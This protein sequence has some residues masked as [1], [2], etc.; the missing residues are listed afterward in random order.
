MT[1]ITPPKARTIETALGG[2]TMERAGEW[3]FQNRGWIPAPFAAVPLLIPAE[4]TLSGWAAGGALMLL[5]EALRLWG[6]AAA[7]PETRRRSRG[8][9]RLVTHGPFAFVRNPIY[10]GNLLLWLGF[11]LASGIEWFP[12]VAGALFAME[13]SAIVRFEEGV[14]V[15]TFGAEYARYRERTPRWVPR[16]ASGAKAGR[17]AWGEAVRRERMTMT[18]ATVLFLALAGKRMVG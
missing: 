11:A 2:A 12:P 1:S 17:M 3:L 4:L 18:L 16:V 7:G 6:V 10:V 5:G 14:L 15:A 13:Y 8:V 9:E